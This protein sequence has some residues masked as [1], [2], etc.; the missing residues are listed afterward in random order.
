M[1]NTPLDSQPTCEVEKDKNNI[2]TIAY[3]NKEKL[4]R[5]YNSIKTEV[6]EIMNETVASR[7]IQR[8]YRR[9]Y[10]AKRLK[11]GKKIMNA[12]IK[13]HGTK[14]KANVVKLYLNHC[15]SLIQHYYRFYKIKS[16]NQINSNKNTE[17][18]DSC[19]KSSLNTLW[20]SR[21]EEVIE[22]KKYLK[23]KQ[24]YDPKKPIEAS[25]R[26]KSV[27]NEINSQKQ[28]TG[29]KLTSIQIDN[30]AKNPSSSNKNS[31]KVMNQK[32]TRNQPLG[33]MATRKSPTLKTNSM[34]HTL[35]ET[36][37]STNRI[38]EKKNFLANKNS[39]TKTS[40]KNS[41]ARKVPV[42]RNRVK[43]E[44]S[45]RFKEFKKKVPNKK[46]LKGPVKKYIED[47][48]VEE[49]AGI[50]SVPKAMEIKAKKPFLRRR[51]KK[52]EPRKINWQGISSRIDCW[53][54]NCK[55]DRSDSPKTNR[56]T[57]VNPRT[58]PSTTRY[59]SNV[60]HNQER[61]KKEI[62][63]KNNGFTAEELKIKYSQYHN[64]NQSKLSLT[65]RY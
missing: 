19:N 59:S 31:I 3:T 6:T 62:P 46:T 50:T 53:G 10:K 28:I 58:S 1:Q 44:P 47:V 48:V 36:K 34:Y 41:T 43:R 51:S 37:S 26:K 64:N 33:N 55:S 21:R 2:T 40:I 35:E 9:Y 24:V 18:T 14:C 16:F 52:V 20:N 11:A 27:Q 61:V 56:K 39:I 49:T 15:A 4:L 25:K 8:A 30:K 12:M 7:K 38:S 60:S 22:K 54:L 17:C 32:S 23:R 57:S 63:I 45:L 13:W 29:N 42:D 65:C 5:H